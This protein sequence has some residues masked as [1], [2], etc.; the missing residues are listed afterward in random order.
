MTGSG[1]KYCPFSNLN[2]IELEYSLDSS[3]SI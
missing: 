3:K 2:N 1:A